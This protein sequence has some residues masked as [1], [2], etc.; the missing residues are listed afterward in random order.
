VIRR[1]EFLAADWL[2]PAAVAVLGAWTFWVSEQ[3]SVS[4]PSWAVV[5]F[6]L[7]GTLALGWRRRWPM[8]VLLGV[9]LADLVPLLAWGT[10]Y[11]LWGILTVVLAVFACGRYAARPVALLSMPLTSALVLLVAVKD[12]ANPGVREALFWS[13]NSVWIFGIG[14]WIRQKQALADRAHAAASEHARAA[15]AEERLRIARDLHDVL[16]HSLAVMVV[17]AE[18][19]DAVLDRDLATARGSLADIA[20]VGRGALAEVHQVIGALRDSVSGGGEDEGAEFGGLADLPTLVA[21]MRSSGLPVSLDVAQAPSG[22]A[23]VVDRAVY[24]L[25]QEALTN[26]LRHAGRVPTQ[27]RVRREDASLIMDV[28]NDHGQPSC[29][30]RTSATAARPG[31]GLIGMRERARM[32]G[33]IVHAGHRPEGG[34]RVHAELPLHGETE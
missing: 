14:A 20:A 31:H 10:A 4:G 8:L 32:I 21:R 6:M 28:E 34:F 27:V 15:A 26:V 12:P 13:L 24:R 1:W 23:P 17:Q 3:G 30:N 25:A 33:G 18:A 16:A 2:P 22:L 9:V 29:P 5:T 7:L 19:A 11:L